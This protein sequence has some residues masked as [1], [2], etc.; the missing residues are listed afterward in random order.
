M[1]L[2]TDAEPFHFC[3]GHLAAASKPQGI[4]LVPFFGVEEMHVV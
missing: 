4:K 1:K 2:V 3:S